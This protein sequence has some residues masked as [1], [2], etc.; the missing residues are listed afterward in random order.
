MTAIDKLVAN[1]EFDR[2]FLDRVKAV[3]VATKTTLHTNGLPAHYIFVF[4]VISCMKDED[5]SLENIS[6]KYREIFG[7][8][9]NA[10]SLTRTLQYLSD[11][12]KRGVLGLISYTENPFTPTDSR[13]KGVQLTRLG[14]NLQ[15][16]LLGTATISQVKI[17]NQINV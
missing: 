9:I 2:A 17:K 3:E 8:G 16:I 13:F 6:V 7:R 4:K 12:H 1:L 14:R 15:K 10:S 5:M 11:D